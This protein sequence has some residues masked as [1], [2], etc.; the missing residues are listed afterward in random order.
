MT[1]DCSWCTLKVD[2][3]GMHALMCLHASDQ[4]EDHLITE[5]MV[6]EFLTSQKITSG[7]S[8]V[9]INAM[10][11]HVMYEQYVC[12]AKGTAATRGENGYYDFKKDMHDMKK[13]PL[14]NADGSVDYK[15]SLSLALV[16]EGE[17][18]A[19]YIPPTEGKPGI[20]I[21]GKIQ[22]ALGRGKELMPLR[23]K[24]I[25]SDDSKINYY[26]EFSGHIVMDGSR[27][28][29]EKLYQI[30]GD[31]DLET[32]NIH[33]D[34]DV[35]VSGDVRSGLE[36]I[37]TGNIYIHGHVGACKLE[38]GKCITIEKGVQGK[39]SCE[40]KA[41][42]NV[43]CK[44]VERCKINSAGNIYADSVLDSTL[45]AENQIIVTSKVGNVVN[46][47]VYGMCGVIVKEAGNNVGTPTLLRT[48]L[49]HEYY[50]RANELTKAIQEID[51]K[52]NSFNHHLETLESAM[53]SDPEKYNDTKMQ[54]TR[55]KIVLSS[56][57]K[58][59]SDELSVL[60]EKIKADRTNSFIN[61]T[62]TVYDNVRIYIGSI[63]YLVTEAVKEVTFRIHNNEIIVESLS[64]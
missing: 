54:I 3:S 7:I 33:F 14:I 21:Y 28:S 64:E 22:P 45:I 12:V 62:G 44:F 40:I 39:D 10:I 11:E 29:I 15:N 34:G 49:P 1:I 57:R 38:A 52:I 26:A 36:I 23:G 35:D 2:N 8:Q 46:S 56:S 32:G 63:P 5:N 37:T 25:K 6:M 18:L 47:E 41:G 48:G 9:A 17:L 50:L 27:I 16:K 59:Y 42:E 43:A 20:D 31:L 55:A 4:D 24:G 60:N 19:T 58:E 61:I 53:A 51:Q 13:K 30:N